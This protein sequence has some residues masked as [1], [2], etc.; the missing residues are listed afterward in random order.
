[1]QIRLNISPEIH[2]VLKSKAELAGQSVSTYAGIIIAKKLKA[3]PP[4]GARGFAAMD[5]KQ[6]QEIRAKVKNP[7]R[8]PL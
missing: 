2:A 6:V 4:T 7:G 8:K 1:M 3:K 5:K